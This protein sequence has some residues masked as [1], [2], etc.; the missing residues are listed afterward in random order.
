MRVGRDVTS[1][2]EDK[3]LHLVVRTQNHRPISEGNEDELS[4]KGLVRNCSDGL[5][6][7]TQCVRFPRGERMRRQK[8]WGHWMM[9]SD[10]P[11][12]AGLG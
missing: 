1:S 7:V 3:V 8:E 10:K 6:L 11:T 9:R 5:G 2:T 12:T 4:K